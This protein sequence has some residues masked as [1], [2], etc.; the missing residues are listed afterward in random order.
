MFDRRTILVTLLTTPLLPIAAQGATPGADAFIG[1]LADQALQTLGNKSLS[2]TAREAKFRHLF[3]ANFGVRRISRFVLGRYWR[4]ATPAERHD[5]VQ[6]FTKYIIAVYVDRL[7]L[8]SG[9]KV[10]VVGTRRGPNGGVLVETTVERPGTP[11]P[12]RVAWRVEGQPGAYKVV[13][14]AIEGVSM[15][16]TERQEFGSVIANNGGNV[17]ALLAALRRRISASAQN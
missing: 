6:L 8:Y 16:I 14:V 2:T 5:Y 7:T 3:L 13:D 17:N 10:Q 11:K 9:L 15:A 4:Q 12:A 1:N